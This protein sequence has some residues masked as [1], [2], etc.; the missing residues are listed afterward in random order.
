MVLSASRRAAARHPMH[1][2]T[3]PLAWRLR[4]DYVSALYRR[5][6]SGTGRA[7]IVLQFA[8]VTNCSARSHNA[9]CALS[10]P[11]RTGADR[12]VCVDAAPIVLYEIGRAHV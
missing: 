4:P 10:L 6:F 3:K 1:S 9:P 12:A 5:S 2:P 11:T 7:R 8:R